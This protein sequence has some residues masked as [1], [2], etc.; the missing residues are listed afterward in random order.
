MKH[1]I[2]VIL[3]FFSFNAFAQIHFEA[4]QDVSTDLHNGQDVYTADIDGDNDLDVISASSHD[5]TIAWYE[6]TD[7]LGTYGPKQVISTNANYAKMVKV[8]DIDGDGIVDVISASAHDDKI[9]WYKNDGSGNFGV[10]QIV[11]TDEDFV[12]EIF[13]ADID[14]DNDMD[15]AAA[16]LDDNTISWYRNDGT[17]NFS[18]KIIIDTNFNEAKSVFIADM[19]GDN[20]MDIVAVAYGIG[21]LAWF[22]NT[23]GNGT[24]S[25]RIIISDAIERIESVAVNDM[26][27]DNEMDIVVTASSG[28][29][30]TWWKNSNTSFTEHLITTNLGTI[31]RISIADFDGDGDFDIS[32]VN[33]LQWPRVY[34]YT[35]TDGLGDFTHAQTLVV[36]GYPVGIHSAD[37]DGDGD[38]DLFTASINGFLGNNDR[39]AWY[40]N[41]STLSV[42]SNV[43]KNY[44]ITPNPTKGNIHI[45]SDKLIREVQIY[46]S[47]GILVLKTSKIESLNISNLSKGVYFIKLIFN[48]NTIVSDKIIKS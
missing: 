31:G 22:E 13:V 37:I 40:E 7:G 42:K 34:I 39:I 14:G 41:T 16:A 24:F 44:K 3:T 8:A 36:I 47:F 29:R 48:D 10:E 12:V 18:S 25:S 17:G 26:D 32:L 5:D 11:S 6:N 4:S 1:L 28:N 38:Y 15:I 35:N 27:G 21:T 43:F 2:L 30:L 33:Y 45:T 9:A 46:N 19:D 20:D 23:D